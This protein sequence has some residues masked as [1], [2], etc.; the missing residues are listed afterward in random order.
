MEE[1]VAEFSF[2][3]K[4]HSDLEDCIIQIQGN[5]FC[6]NDGDRTKA[7]TVD[8]IKIDIERAIEEDIDL[9][10]LLIYEHEDVYEALD[11]IYVD[12]DI[13]QYKDEIVEMWPD[14]YGK[15]LGI[16]VIVKSLP[17]QEYAG[18]YIEVPAMYRAMRLNSHGCSLVLLCAESLDDAV[19][20]YALLLGFRELSD[21]RFM[22]LNTVVPNP[23]LDSVFNADLMDRHGST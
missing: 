7:C 12:N 6:V 13:T 3:S 21:K 16:L 2:G 20:N 10:D 8:A 9:Y 18:R 19:R 1:F 15:G 17:S 22:I 5:V 11:A 23:D 14:C 4:L